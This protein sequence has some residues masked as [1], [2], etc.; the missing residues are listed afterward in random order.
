MM[1]WLFEQ[2]IN[3][4]RLVLISSVLLYGQQHHEQIHVRLAYLVL[5]VAHIL[6]TFDNT[7]DHY[8]IIFHTIFSPLSQLI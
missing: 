4:M 2:N 5:Y 8:M 7:Q 6:A 1:C 3:Q